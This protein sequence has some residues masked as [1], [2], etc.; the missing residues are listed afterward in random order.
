[1]TIFGYVRVSTVDQ[2]NGPEA[3]RM[4]IKGRVQV[5]SWHED[6]ASG[7]SLDRPEIASI[8]T[9]VKPGDTIVVAKLDRLSRSVVDAGTIM[10]RAIKEGWNIIAL[11]LG[12][13]LS[14]PA[15]KMVASVVM[16]MAEFEREVGQ[17]DWQASQVP[18]RR[19]RAHPRATR[20]GTVATSD[21]RGVQHGPPNGRPH[22]QTSYSLSNFAQVCLHALHW[23]RTPTALI[24]SSR[25]SLRWKRLTGTILLRDIPRPR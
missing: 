25:L 9:K 22:R 7:K 16:A 14:T 4:A 12:V 10:A 23:C 18:A 20:E 1:M 6:R 13:D 3:Q 2:D 11:D 8:L 21:R 17:A 5:D 19:V 24:L 15:G